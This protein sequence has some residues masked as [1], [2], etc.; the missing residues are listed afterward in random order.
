VLTCSR[1]VLVSSRSGIVKERGRGDALASKYVPLPLSVWNA[2]G[3]VAWY[4]LATANGPAAAAAAPS[5]PAGFHDPAAGEGDGE[6][7]DAPCHS[8]EPEPGA[9]VVADGGAAPASPCDAGASACH[10][11]SCAADVCCG[12][13]STTGGEVADAAAAG[14]ASGVETTTGP[15]PSWMDE[16][17]AA[18]DSCCC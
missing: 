7:D 17:G 2:S 15:G 9:A 8:P 16:S 1:T 14:S 11:P 18:A 3:C 6:A 4:T 12:A 5:T 13:P 10:A